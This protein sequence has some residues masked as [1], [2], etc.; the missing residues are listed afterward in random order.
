MNTIT[1]TDDTNIIDF[2]DDDDSLQAFD[3]AFGDVFRSVV[4]T[5]NVSLLRRVLENEGFP[6]AEINKRRGYLCEENMFIFF[7]KDVFG[8]GLAPP[9]NGYIPSPGQSEIFDCFVQCEKVDINIPTLVSGL[10]PL[11][12]CVKYG[13]YEFAKKLVSRG[14]DPYLFFSDTWREAAGDVLFDQTYGMV[15]YLKRHFPENTDFI[16]MMQE[17]YNATT[18]T[19]TK[20]PYTLRY[21]SVSALNRLR[22]LHSAMRYTTFNAESN[23]LVFANSER[24]RGTYVDD[25]I[26]EIDDDGL[27]DVFL[28]CDGGNPGDIE[29]VQMTIFS[30]RE[31]LRASRLRS[32]GEGEDEE[33]EDADGDEDG[34]GAG[35]GFTTL[36]TF[37]ELIREIN[38]RENHRQN[39]N[40]PP[41]MLGATGPFPLSSNHE[42]PQPEQP[43]LF[44]IAEPIV[45]IQ[46]RDDLP[47]EFVCSV[48]LEPY[49]EPCVNSCGEMY[50]KPCIKSLFA[51]GI[52]VDPRTRKK[53]KRGVFT[54]CLAVQRMM[55]EYKKN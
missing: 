21:N 41:F 31:Y 46:Y 22:F 43:E 35:S 2:V 39:T 40:N 6:A 7:L 33:E 20:G 28:K 1:T 5:S 55:N 32:G 47:S 48:C 53:M 27:L 15:E 3:R 25:L 51:S 29:N 36:Q 10:S 50:C 26:F 38:N 12:L 30:E 45:R 16:N 24:V 49:H 19:V 11:V 8:T 44:E 23:T 54:L 13:C 4:R 9:P 42:R 37:V 17:Y 14:A 34:G 18:E 52:T